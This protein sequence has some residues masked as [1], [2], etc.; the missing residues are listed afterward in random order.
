MKKGKSFT[1]RE[2]FTSYVNDFLFELSV[3]NINI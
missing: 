3:N 1:K 2:F